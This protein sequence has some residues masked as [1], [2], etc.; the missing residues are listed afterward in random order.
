MAMNKRLTV[1][2]VII[3]AAALALGAFWYISTHVKL[4]SK[5]ERRTIVTTE[6]GQ[7]LERYYDEHGRYPAVN[8]NDELMRELS[9]KKYFDTEVRIDIVRY[10]PINNGQRYE[11]H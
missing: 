9:A 2:F 6:L 3:C 4:M 8:T 1:L 10:V 7:A 5:E 11:L